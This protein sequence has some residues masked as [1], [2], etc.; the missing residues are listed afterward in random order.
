M[1]GGR[2]SE[3]AIVTGA[4]RGLGLGIS[5]ALCERGCKVVMTARN[6]AELIPVVE[7]LA[8][9]GY[10]VEA[11]FCD[12]TDQSSI[13]ALF[14]HVEKTYGKIDIL[15]NNAGILLD[16]LDQ[17][18]KDIAIDTI[19]NSFNTNSLGSYRMMVTMLPLL[20]KSEM[21][22]VVNLSSTAGQ[23]KEMGAR[24]PAY[25][26]SK[27]ALNALTKLFAAEYSS[28]KLKINAVCPNWVRTRMG[29]KHAPFSVEESVRGIMW[30]ATLDKNGPSGGF[31][32]DCEAIDW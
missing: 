7:D 28:E 22:R 21:A 16:R 25:R 4:N 11:F 14:K 18:L 15:I 6:L 12:V 32:R 30:A 13:D 27:A 1:L 17:E 31:Y 26:S 2:M 3:V 20:Q 19:L 8:K 5:K 24:L 10:S 29:G 23:L 9:H